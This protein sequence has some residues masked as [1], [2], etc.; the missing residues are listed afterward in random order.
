MS[1]RFFERYAGQIEVGAP[2]GCWLWAGGTISS[3]YGSVKAR[4][5][6]RLAH[7]EAYEDVHG[8]GSA[9]GLQVRHRCDTPVCVNPSHLQLGTPADNMR[10]KVER[11]RARSGGIKGETCRQAKLTDSDVLAIRSGYVRGC[12]ESGQY[13]LAERFGVSQ[14]LISQVINREKWKHI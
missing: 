5:K 13:A 6:S 2:T 11:G 10:D 7:R 9:D 1:E 14:Q 12:S 8:L 4:G 3:G